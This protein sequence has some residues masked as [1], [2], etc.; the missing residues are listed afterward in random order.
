[1]NELDLLQPGVVVLDIRL[2]D[3]HVVKSSDLSE[4]KIAIQKTIEA[5]NTVRL[6][7]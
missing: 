7:V 4:L 3:Y 5:N 1:V 6:T 2:A